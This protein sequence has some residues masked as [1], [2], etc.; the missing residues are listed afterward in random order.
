MRASQA[1]TPNKKE[2]TMKTNELKKGDMVQLRCGWKARI[3]DNLKGNIR[4]AYVLG[5]FPEMGSIYAHDIVGKINDN[6]SLTAI[7]YTP[8]QVK[9]AQ[10]ILQL[11]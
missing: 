7:E 10:R 4:M 9:L 6:G 1:T 11:F 2:N 3:E 5:Y 8:A